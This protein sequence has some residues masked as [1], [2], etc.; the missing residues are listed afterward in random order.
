MAGEFY[1][2]EHVIP[3][4][5]PPEAV[6]DAFMSSRQHAAFTGL[7]ARLSTVV[8][9]RFETCGGR[10]F[11]WNLALERGRRIV[12]AWSHR[13]L[14]AG[15]FTIAD[16]SLSPARR[17]TKL[18]FRHVGVP[19]KHAGWLDEGWKTT[20]WIPLRAHLEQRA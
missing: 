6:Y 5:A 12:Q 19:A 20:Y 14:P 1:T 9:G 15:Q 10:N 16:L 4:A 7:A 18:V 11:G 17:G 13:D 3:I 8:G 2:L